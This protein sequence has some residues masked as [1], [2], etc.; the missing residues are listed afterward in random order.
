MNPLLFAVVDAV[1][2]SRARYAHNWGIIDALECAD[3][4]IIHVGWW[5][6]TWEGR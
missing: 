5:R 6:S 3:Q 1:F 2:E 4:I